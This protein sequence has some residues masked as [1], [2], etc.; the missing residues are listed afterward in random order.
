MTLKKRYLRV[1]HLLFIILLLI[2]LIPEQSTKPAFTS[3]LVKFAIG[4]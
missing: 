4:F 2:Q 1:T 3:S